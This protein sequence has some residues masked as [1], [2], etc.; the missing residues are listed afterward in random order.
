MPDTRRPAVAGQFYP[1]APDELAGAVREYV[2]AGQTD[3]SEPVP[4]AIIAP[5]AG[6]AYSGPVAGAAYARLAPARGRVERVVL[7]GPAH[8]VAVRGLALPQAD[9]FATPLGLVPV[10][11]THREALLALG[12][13]AVLDRAHASEHSLEV[14]LPF[15]QH[16]L[17]GFRLVP[18]VVGMASDEEVAAVLEVLWGGPET[19]VVVSSDLSHYLDYESA[20]RMDAATSRAVE[21]L[22]PQ[23]IAPDQACGRGPVGGLLLTARRHELSVATVDLRNSGDTA[24][25]RDR[26]VG[27]G[28]YVFC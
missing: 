25:G 8:R 11:W 9:F 6:Y 10:D 5:H 1:S 13:V 2:A 17:G 18:L 19:L 21:E 27:Y 22:R 16:V 4:K 28:A 3:A 14:Q 7:L 12:C 24:G 26:V 20:Q 23:D 15:L